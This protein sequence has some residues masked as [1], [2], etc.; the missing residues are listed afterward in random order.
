VSKVRYHTART[1]P[2]VEINTA[3][4]VSLDRL[5]G[6]GPVYAKRILKYRELL[7]GFCTLDQLNEV[8]GLKPEIIMKFRRF[9]ILDTMRLRKIN[10]KLASFKEVNAHPYITF[11]QTKAIFRLR[12]QRKLISCVNLGK[13]M[14]FDSLQWKKVRS[15]L[16]VKD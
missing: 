15:Y 3:D 10:L 14:I 13:S 2:L 11:E 4:S 6:I 9:L 5:P 1:L 12:E 16:V 7:G 8:Y